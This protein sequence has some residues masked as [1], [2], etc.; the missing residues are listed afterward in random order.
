MNHRSNKPLDR[1]VRVKPLA[2]GLM[3]TTLALVAMASHTAL[4]SEL[5]YVHPSPD[6]AEEICLVPSYY[7][8]QDLKYVN[9]DSDREDE[10]KLCRLTV[11]EGMASRAKVERVGNL[12]IDPLPAKEVV[13]CPKLNSTNP[14]TNFVEIPNG[15]TFTQAKKEFCVP[16]GTIDGE[17]AEDYDLDAKFKSTISCSSTAS[18]LGYYHLSRI[19]GGAGRVPVAVLR[20]LSR[21]SHHQIVEQ[22]ESILGSSDEIIAKNWRTFSAASRNA[23]AGRPSPKLY[24]DGGRLLY[25]ALQKNLKG[26]DKYT[27]VSGVGTYEGR[28]ARFLQQRPFQLVAD[29][30]PVEQIAG[31]DF[32]E[33]AQSIVQ[34]QDVSDMVLMDTL[35]SQ[36]DR[37]GNIHVKP[38]VL[39]KGA[40]QLRKMKK[41]EES[42]LKAFMKQ[43]SAE[44]KKKNPRAREAQF[45]RDMAKRATALIFPKGE[46]AVVAAMHLKDN[47]CG[48]DVDIRGNQMRRHNALESVRHMSP[49]TYRRFLKFAVEVDSGRFKPFAIQSLTYR[50]KDYEGT[51]Y[52][53]RENVRHAA[54][55][56]IEACERGELKLDLALNFDAN[57]NFRP[58]APVAC[59]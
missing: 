27:E 6:G 57:G 13:A 20:T 42:A 14:G 22:A 37:I 45:N 49:D 53:L 19:L 48:T 30:R 34:M 40:T 17:F 38:W 47:D 39:E 2:A 56:L 21:E 59:R 15:M 10:L 52:S 54:K 8:T 18:A 9:L 46:A 23:A 24:T 41:S 32:F 1:A 55:V 43:V 35:M 4:A 58:P 29:A 7:E 11:Y 50:E 33:V 12:S 26:E 5:R 16:K 31:A 3:G 28:Y 25:G 51:R 36:D 44:L